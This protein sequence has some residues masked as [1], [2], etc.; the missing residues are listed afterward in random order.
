MSAYQE[1]GACDV[2]PL[3]KGVTQI[4][5]EWASMRFDSATRRCA[6]YNFR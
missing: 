1:G 3:L 2:D 4:T 6:S 5:I